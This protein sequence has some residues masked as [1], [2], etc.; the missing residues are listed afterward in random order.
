MFTGTASGV[1]CPNDTK[2]IS[3]SAQKDGVDRGP[4]DH[5]FGSYSE[6]VITEALVRERS[7]RI[8]SRLDSV[9]KVFFAG[10]IIRY[11]AAIVKKLIEDFCQLSIDVDADVRCLFG[12]RQD[13]DLRLLYIDLYL[14]HIGLPVSGG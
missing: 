6:G 5:D 14:H 12:D 11:G 3:P 8:R 4:E 10:D 2:S 9:V 1:C 7:V 13:E